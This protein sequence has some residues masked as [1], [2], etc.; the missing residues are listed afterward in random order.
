MRWVS[1]WAVLVLF[2][3]QGHGGPLNR[4]FC[5]TICNPN[6]EEPLRRCF[7]NCGFL[8]YGKYH[9][10]SRCWYFVG[11]GKIINSKGYCNRGACLKVFT[12]GYEGSD[13]Q[14]YCEFHQTKVPSKNQ[15]HV[16]G[17]RFNATQATDNEPNETYS[18]K[19]S[20]ASHQLKFD[21]N[22]SSG[23]LHMPSTKTRFVEAPE[24]ISE[25]NYTS[26]LP[27][28]PIILKEAPTN[29][30]QKA[31]SSDSLPITTLAGIKGIAE[32][33]PKEGGHNLKPSQEHPAETRPKCSPL[34]T[35]STQM[36]VLSVP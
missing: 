16:K 35:E 25:S 27:P 18:T 9:D 6:P 14:M 11:T 12:S 7:Y 29:H 1:I 34:K 13:A 21:K 10:G 2:A 26:T 15:T 3:V 23:I 31:T 33:P 8:K 20:Y 22:I 24:R 19:S 4:L 32:Y 30:E 36:I 5:P 17:E 28:T